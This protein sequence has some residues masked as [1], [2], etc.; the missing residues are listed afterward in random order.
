[1]H[2]SNPTVTRRHFV[3]TATAA[4]AASLA[5]V[6]NGQS[7][8]A[9]S[10]PSPARKSAAGKL[11]IAIIGVR[12]P[13]Y[14]HL[15]ELINGENIVALCDVDN[16]HMSH[17]VLQVSEA[18]HPEILRA[19]RFQ[20]YRKLFAEMADAIDAVVVAT[21]DH[22]HF[23]AAMLA[24]RHRKHV[25]VQKPL[26]R[27]VGEARALKAAARAAGVMTQMG[28]QYH[29]SEG[30]RLVRE[31]FELGL[32]GEVREVVAWVPGNAS[33]FLYRPAAI[34]PASGFIDTHFDWD[35]W[36]GPS[37][38]RDF[39]PGCYH[40]KRWR[41]WWD[42][43]TGLLGDWA[44]HTLDAPYWSL[45]LGAPISVEAEVSESNPWFVPKTAVIRY[46]FPARG[47]LPPVKLTWHEGGPKPAVP[48]DWEAGKPLPAAGMM[49]LGSRNTLIT[50]TSPESPR[51]VS[52]AAMDELKRNRPER[53][54]DR[55]PGGH[56]AEWTRAI[57]GEGPAPGS[58]FVDYAADLTQVALLGL[59]AMRT[60][61][62][63]EWDNRAGRI[64]NDVALN[65]HIEIHA[66]NGWKVT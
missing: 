12:G 34:P 60:G 61:R 47:K 40:A 16:T 44:C 66:R 54:L 52:A 51:L 39:A 30:I 9:A 59:V 55:V 22:H 45:Q 35:V 17:T 38:Q 13:G 4:A 53:W 10:A 15:R 46:E 49:M 41:G 48:R 11:N 63:I 33:R 26:T 2:A 21:P 64:T 57:K 14:G 42:F 3:R 27:T 56:L 31:W 6:T 28:N 1:M 50:G 37:P 62:R 18:G 25:F 8:S 36:L 20:D 32:L 24:I 43:G 23:P 7:P 19:K 5:T 58:N 65:K 29:A